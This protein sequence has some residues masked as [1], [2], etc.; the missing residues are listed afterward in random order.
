MSNKL[1]AGIALWC[2][3]MTTAVTATAKE[4]DTKPASGRGEVG[5]PFGIPGQQATDDVW[6]QFLAGSDLTRAGNAL[7]FLNELFD[8]TG[9]L[10][11]ALCKSREQEIRE[12]LAEIPVSAGMWFYG[13]RC[14]E[15]NGDSE[16]AAQSEAVLAALLENALGQRIMASYSRPIPVLGENDIYAILELSGETVLAQAYEVPV[17]GRY[18]RLIVS[19][20]D[21]DSKRQQSMYFDF[22]DNFVQLARDTPELRMPSGRR[23]FALEL[24]RG[25]DQSEAA[26]VARD[27]WE[28]LLKDS[29]DGRLEAVRA[30]AKKE[31]GHRL[32]VGLICVTVE[33]FDCAAE[34]VELLLPYAEAGLADAYVVLA[35]AYAEGR[36][37]ERDDEAALAMLA[38]ANRALGPPQAEVSLQV[39]LKSING[40]TQLHPLVAETLREAAAAGNPLASVP[41]ALSTGDWTQDQI[42]QEALPFLRVAAD[43]GATVALGLAGRVHV[44]AGRADVGLP[45]LRRAADAGDQ[46]SALFLGLAYLRGEL[47]EA[48]VEQARH[49]LRIGAEAGEVRSMRVLALDYG[50]QGGAENYQLA[51]SWFSEAVLLGD[52]QASVLMARFLLSEPEGVEDAPKRA[53]ILL[54]ALIAE[55]DSDEARFDLGSW[56]LQPGSPVYAPEQGLALV[57]K[58]GENGHQMA[59]MF[60]A[61]GGLTAPSPE[62]DVEL[63]Q[64]WLEQGIENK[65]PEIAV[66][67]SAVLINA[68]PEYRDVPR[69]LALLDHWWQ[70]EQNASALNELA[71]LRCTSVDPEVF[72][73]EQSE[74]LGPAL[75]KVAT[76]RLDWLDTVAACQAAAG[77]FELAVATQREV[78]A[79]V[80]ARAGPDNPTVKSMKA[81]LQRYQEGKRA[82]ER[83]KASVDD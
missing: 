64:R 32:W 37:V 38:E 16:L 55:H 9:E 41:V 15:L 79:E 60:Y 75:A 13:G 80:E 67:L 83:I 81:R 63:A 20:L 23:Q 66:P 24:L 50:R 7:R 45:M 6:K 52:E 17:T 82:E 14:A 42:P 78:I 10:D 69:G 71:W 8:E 29:V 28:A 47:L 26:I 57:R 72:S 61:A 70:E 33:A 36:G 12:A 39:L 44:E 25:L 54:E 5:S 68:K 48:D 58:A 30:L 34:G 56:K 35:V 76:D 51:D 22:L 43:G 21:E 11:P 4:S 2:L 77:D 40:K 27:A 46:L 62:I 3:L 74:V 73:R 31:D 18:M 49:W 19:T 1:L 59:R 65:D 53:R